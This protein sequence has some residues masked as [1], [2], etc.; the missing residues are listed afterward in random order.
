ME[1][2]QGGEGRC[3]SG[4]IGVSDIQHWQPHV[5]GM[6]WHTKVESKHRGTSTCHCWQQVISSNWL[7]LHS[8]AELP[9]LVPLVKGRFR[10]QLSS[11]PP[12]HAADMVADTIPL[13]AVMPLIVTARKQLLPAHQREAPPCTKT[14]ALCTH[15]QPRHPKCNLPLQPLVC[16]PVLLSLTLYGLLPSP[17]VVPWRRL[18]ASDSL[19]PLVLPPLVL[20]GWLWAWCFIICFSWIEGLL[21]DTSMPSSGP[22]LASR[23]C[24]RYQGDCRGGG[25]RQGQQVGSTA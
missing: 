2:R 4:V 22:S 13:A 20:L 9:L 24:C 18:L 3:S 14:P 15:H 12:G 8:R 21:G 17:C 16:V 25:M 7:W 6:I 19:E 5:A 23:A 1:R 11:T 10:L